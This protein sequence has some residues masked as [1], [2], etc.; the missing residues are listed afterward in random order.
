[1]NSTEESFR[2][3]LDALKEKAKAKGVNI[4]ECL[5]ENEKKLIDLPNVASNDMIHGAT[6]RVNEAI[7][8]IQTGLNQVKQAA[9]DVATIKAEVKKCGHGWKAIKCIAKLLIKVEEE[10]VELPKN[11][12]DAVSK[13][14]DLVENIKPRI[15]DCASQKVDEVESQ[16]KKI[17]EDIGLCVAKKLIGH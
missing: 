2:K 17:L 7:G 16:G 5:G 1:M 13:V 6:D 12:H 9:D 3:Q 14:V 11:L 8:Y 15:Q 4:D 10:I